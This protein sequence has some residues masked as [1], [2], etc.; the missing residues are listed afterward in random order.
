MRF[1]RERIQRAAERKRK[2]FPIARSVRPVCAANARKR[3]KGNVL[4]G[5]RLNAM[6]TPNILVH[7]SLSGVRFA[8]TRKII[9]II[10]TDLNSLQCNWG[11]M[12]R[13]FAF[14]R[15]RGVS[16]M[17]FFLFFPLSLCY[18]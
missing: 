17:F 8:R 7:V 11:E 16:V 3:F 12:Q 5:T 15:L 14:L 9:I 6:R 4:E 2:T 1:R 13:T 10:I 18:Y